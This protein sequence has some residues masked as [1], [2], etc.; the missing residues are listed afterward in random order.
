MRV[1]FLAAYLPSPSTHGASRRVDGLMRR[2][3][4]AHS[5]S[6]LALA[7]PGADR[8]AQIRATSEY[9]DDVIAVDSERL[10]LAEGRKRRLQVRSLV[11]RFSY[12]RYQ[13]HLPAYQEALDRLLL[14]RSFD[15]VNVESMQMG[16]YAI[17]RELPVILDEHNIE[18]EVLA[19]TASAAR[20]SLRRFYSFV[21]AWKL[22]RE[23]EQL[24]RSVSACALT[25][26][27]EE[28][29]VHVAAPQTPTAVVP[30]GVDTSFFCPTGRRG[31][32][33]TILFF[34][35]LDYYPNAD[36]VRFLV[37]GVMPLLR[38]RRRRTTLVV[39]GRGAPAR[40]QALEAEDVK[41]R[42]EVP[43]V[44]SEIES[45]AVVV[46]PLRVGGGTR[47]KILEAMSMAR[48]V[49][50]TAV[51]AE[52][53]AVT[54]GRELVIADDVGAFASA[55]GDLLDDPE[56]QRALADRGRA[57]VESL[58]DWRTSAGQLQQLYVRATR[59]VGSPS[60]RATVD[61]SFG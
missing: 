12:E 38:R 59:G 57:L 24:W 26:E 36:A 17:P 28:A 11:S 54:S 48:P 20:G 18:Y 55:V 60:Q 45:A 25:S 35:A 30:N 15:L 14:R 43:D 37:N 53:L 2:L 33:A 44:R 58:Y 50:S 41:F 42:G 3:A 5:V 56:R 1:L 61:G 51:G 29:I 46:A 52:G 9:C 40:L 34:G 4:A 16:A 31:D 47:L 8:T 23:E 19:R 10:V 27:R 49:V 13:F 39:V 6:V 21:D 32:G 22:R 7:D